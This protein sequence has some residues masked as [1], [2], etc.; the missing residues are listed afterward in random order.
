MTV[1]APANGYV[2]PPG[3]YMLFVLNADGVP[4]EAAFVAVRDPPARRRGRSAHG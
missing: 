3:P 4:S 1:Q 2:A